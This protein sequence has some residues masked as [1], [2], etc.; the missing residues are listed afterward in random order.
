MRTLRVEALPV[1]D[2]EDVLEFGETVNQCIKQ[3][4]E[5]EDLVARARSRAIPDGLIT[6]F[7][8]QYRQSEPIW[9]VL[10]SGK[11]YRSGY[12]VAPDHYRQMYEQILIHERQRPANNKEHPEE[13]QG[14]SNE[15][16]S[17]LESHLV[18]RTFFTTRNGL[19]GIGMAGIRPGDRVTIW[20]GAP[21]PFIV[22]SCASPREHLCTLIGAA[23]VG[24]IMEGEMVDELYCEDL[25]DSETLFVI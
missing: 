19:A 4:P 10:V 1:D 5:V 22:R 15:Y 14:L 25:L 13:Y 7:F 11:K 6:P 20:F 8:E 9:R 12:D 21:V 17:A 23:Y 3:L 16:R 24:G 18:N 2:V